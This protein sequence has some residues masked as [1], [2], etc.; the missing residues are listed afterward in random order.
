MKAK[1]KEWLKF[2]NVWDN[3]VFKYLSLSYKMEQSGLK[4]GVLTS[5]LLNNIH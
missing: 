1:L 5:V 3:I 2:L 4:N